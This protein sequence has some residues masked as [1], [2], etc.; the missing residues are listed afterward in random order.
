[1]ASRSFSPFVLVVCVVASSV[2]ILYVSQPTE[3]TY[4]SGIAKEVHPGRMTALCS[5]SGGAGRL[6]GRAH[7]LLKARDLDA[8]I[9]GIGPHRGRGDS[10]CVV[11]E[12]GVWADTSV[13]VLGAVARCGVA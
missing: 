6:G 9:L 8:C 2:G 4:T 10:L 11:R 3:H 13:A 5:H 7:A 1:M 12:V